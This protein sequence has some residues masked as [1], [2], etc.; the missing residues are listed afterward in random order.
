MSDLN[1]GLSRVPK[2]IEGIK[3]TG[4]QQNM[5]VLL[6]NNPPDGGNL[7]EDL[8]EMIL[9]PEYQDL[10]PGFRITELRAIDSV[11]WSNARKYLLEM[12]P[13]LR[14]RVDER[15]GIRDVTGKAPIQ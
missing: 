5:L 1:L 3:L 12:D 11:Y 10:L 6:A 2:S 7:L 9:S 15:N 13:D 4:K 8:K 14:A